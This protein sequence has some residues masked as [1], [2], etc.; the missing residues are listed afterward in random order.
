MKNKTQ[1]HLSFE[2]LYHRKVSQGKYTPLAMLSTRAA[3]ESGSVLSEEVEKERDAILAQGFT[4]CESHTELSS[5]RI[6]TADKGDVASVIANSNP[7][8]RMQNG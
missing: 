2:P 7:L 5:A 4:V 3:K 1:K 6:E 8:F